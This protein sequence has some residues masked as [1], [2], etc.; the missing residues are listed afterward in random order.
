[1]GYCVCG[2]GASSHVILD[3]V[4]P[5]T[6]CM[7]TNYRVSAI[8]I[9]AKVESVLHPKHYNSHPSGIECIAIIQWMTHN[10]GQAMK[11]LWRA[12]LKGDPSITTIE[13][14]NKAMQYTWF[15]IKRLGGVPKYGPIEGPEEAEEIP[16]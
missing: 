5:C 16:K 1:M 7:C 12:G 6:L 15:E 3:G 14:L 8:K 9:E 13:D 2:H 11:Y 4:I 10:S